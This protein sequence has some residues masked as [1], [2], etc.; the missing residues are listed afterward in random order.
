MELNRI[1]NAFLDFKFLGMSNGHAKTQEYLLEKSGLIEEPELLIE[2]EKIFESV[3]TR[4]AK[5]KSKIKA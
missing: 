2:F 4:R 1:I 5:Q 3:T